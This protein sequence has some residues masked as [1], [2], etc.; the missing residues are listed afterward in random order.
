[1]TRR[2][3]FS[4][5]SNTPSH[6]SSDSTPQPTGAGDQ[7]GASGSEPSGETLPDVPDLITASPAVSAEIADEELEIQREIE[8]F[9]GSRTAGEFVAAVAALLKVPDLASADLDAIMDGEDPGFQLCLL[10]AAKGGEASERA[11]RASVRASVVAL[12]LQRLRQA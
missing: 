9:R 6:P 11:S 3:I 5:A 2:S 7:Q 8:R 4:N 1:M 10:E 12:A